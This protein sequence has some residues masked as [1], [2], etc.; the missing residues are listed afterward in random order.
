M[1]NPVMICVLLAVATSTTV[2]ATALAKESSPAELERAG[3]SCVNPAAAFPA[4]PNLHCFPPGKLEGVI[5]KLKDD[6]A[7][8][9]AAMAGVWRRK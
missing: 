7:D 2:V 3:W 5:A 4:N 9:V 8:R 1:R 6:V